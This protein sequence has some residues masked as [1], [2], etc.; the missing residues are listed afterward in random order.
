MADH[1]E[2]IFQFDGTSI[3]DNYRSLSEIVRQGHITQGNGQR[4][5][6]ERLREITD[7]EHV[8]LTTTGTAA[9]HTV[10][11]ATDIDGTA[12]EVII[13]SYIS[14][15]VLIALRWAKKVPRFVDMS[16][17][18]FS[19]DISKI[20]LAINEKTHAAIIPYGYG[21][22]VSFTEL[23]GGNVLIIEDICHCTG[24][25]INGQR[26]GSFGHVGI[27]SFGECKYLDGGFGGAI[28]TN[29]KNIAM[30]I[31]NLTGEFQS[32]PNLQAH[33]FMPNVFADIIYQ[34]SFFLDEEIE[35]RREIA[36]IYIEKFKNFDIEILQTDLTRSFYHRFMIGVK[37]KNDFLKKIREEGIMASNGIRTPLHISTQSTVTLPE[38]ERYWNNFIAI[39]IRP[40]LKRHEVERIVATVIRCL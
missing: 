23:L 35:K 31:E 7:C 28:F 39:P 38:T 3:R 30:Q 25:R 37:N 11:R 20:N 22:Y 1:M 15:S 17:H 29:D 19:I 32:Q 21:D 4:L 24:G 14:D 13:P 16:G 2:Q 8:I 5:L 18:N 40:S 26:L 12:N 33:Y 9:I 36:E 34:N 6:I 27:T 10:L